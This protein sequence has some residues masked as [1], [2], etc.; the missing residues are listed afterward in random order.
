MAARKKISKNKK[1]IERKEWG[2]WT[3]PEYALLFSVS[4]ATICGW[5]GKGLLGSAKIGGSRRIF[6]SHDKTFRERFG[7]QGG[8][9]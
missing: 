2:P 8:E 7:S 4:R 1:I 5:I 6:P 3:V 9:S